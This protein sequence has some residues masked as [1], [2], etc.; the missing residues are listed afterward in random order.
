[1]FLK[2]TVNPSSTLPFHMSQNFPLE[3]KCPCVY[4]QDRLRLSLTSVIV[5]MSTIMQRRCATCGWENLQSGFLRSLPLDFAAEWTWRKENPGGTFNLFFYHTIPISVFVRTA[6]CWNCPRRDKFL[7]LHCCTDNNLSESEKQAWQFIAVGWGIG[8][9]GVVDK[10]ERTAQDAWVDWWRMWKMATNTENLLS[11]RSQIIDV[12]FQLVFLHTF[13]E[14]ACRLDRCA[15]PEWIR[16][17][18][19]RSPLLTPPDTFRRRSAAFSSCAE[20]PTWTAK[21]DNPHAVLSLWF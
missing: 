15:S 4:I 13:Q 12:Q 16:G 20:Q 6:S 10:D 9:V 8:I 11:V 5:H 7:Q 19:S 14:Q 1:M 3:I 17:V 2:C 18:G 21:M